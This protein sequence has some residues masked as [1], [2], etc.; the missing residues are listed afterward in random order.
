MC[1]KSNV[2]DSYTS[3]QSPAEPARLEDIPAV[4]VPFTSHSERICFHQR[5]VCQVAAPQFEKTPTIQ[6]RQ[7]KEHMYSDQPVIVRKTTLLHF[8][9]KRIGVFG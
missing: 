5:G 7:E 8:K 6:H 1:F 4:I 9:G 3:L 2:C